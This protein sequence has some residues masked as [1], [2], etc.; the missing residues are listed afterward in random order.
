VGSASAF[1]PILDGKSL[2]FTAQGDGLFKDES[3]GSMWNILGQAV[4]GPSKGESLEPL[5]AVNH[6]WFDWVAFKPETRV[7]GV[8]N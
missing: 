2:T 3:T 1:S 6:F 5:T 7:Y 8:E 4:S